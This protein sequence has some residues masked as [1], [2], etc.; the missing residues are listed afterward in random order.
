MRILFVI[1]SLEYGGSAKQ[2]SLLA[3]GLPRTSFEPLVCTLGRTGPGGDPLGRADVAVVSL[4]W[5][6]TLDV[7]PLRRLR[8]LV[9]T[10]RPAVVHAFER[11]SLRA[12][13]VVGARRKAALVVSA[14]L[15]SNP[16]GD[17]WARLDHLLLRGADCVVA[18]GATEASRYR[19]AGVSERKLAC[20]PPGVRSRDAWKSAQAAPPCLAG[21]PERA[22]LV[23]C[24]GPLEPRGGFVDAVWAFDILKFLYD[25]LHLVLVGGG[26]GRPRL[27]QFVRAIQATD[28]VHFVGY[29]S[30]VTALLTRSEVV[31]VPN[32]A[33][34]GLN[35]AL[36]AMA[37][38][39]PVVASRLSG[40]MEVIA[41]G[42]TGFLV[43]PGDKVA[44]A[45]HTRLLLDDP[46]RGRE[47]G[48]AGCQLA[49]SRF[50]AAS[51]V[52]AHAR[53]YEL[54]AGP[55]T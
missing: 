5:K 27:E 43:R 37:V 22:R 29:Q 11:P 26:S 53:L 44:L 52:Q 13:R 41:D 33:A 45:R 3:T 55:G 16:T 38:G 9:S 25:D 40:L 32:R 8:R 36:E 1:P 4:G 12:A 54:L 24:V 10:F 19:H 47:M 14:G 48:E 35:G 15:E 49:A 30:D 31:W 51:L 18:T 7:N 50:S 23:V 46:G 21:L 34:G 42:Q 28:R 2:L 20:I 6:R 39:R 17:L